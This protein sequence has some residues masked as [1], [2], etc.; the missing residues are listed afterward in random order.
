MAGAMAG[1]AILATRSHRDTLGTV[2][3]TVNNI[4]NLSCPHCY[5]QYFGPEGTIQEEVINH[6]LASD[7]E[8]ICIVGKEPLADAKSIDVVRRIVELASGRG[9]SVSL[10]SN[11]L[12]G[13]LLPA[14]VLDKLTWIDV[15]L[16]GGPA[17]YRAYR[18]GSWEKL[19]RSVVS[20][21]TKGLRELRLLQTLSS[22]T[23]NCI[24]DMLEARRVLGA[25]LTV[26]SPYQP[27]RLQ[28]TQAAAMVSPMEVV[29]A[30]APYANDGSIHL[31]FDRGY[32]SRFEDAARAITLASE[33]FRDRFIYVD[34]DPIDRGIIR[35]T[36]DGL[37]LSP[38]ESINTDDYVSI[39]RSILTQPLDV[40][41]REMLTPMPGAPLH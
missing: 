22:A 28:G 31:S 19:E 30:L 13:S 34:T 17:S 8:R 7:C 1:S 37:V 33:M 36:Y 41:F 3:L 5:L 35:V 10:I 18:R 20:M 26:F 6:V 27:T 39:G 23:I 9:K 40:W 25:S 32:V 29:R 21:R 38:F 14:A 24:P 4:C 12:N 11:G 16:D 2:T 15:S